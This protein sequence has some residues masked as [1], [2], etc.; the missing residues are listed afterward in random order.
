MAL[1]RMI[2][3]VGLTKEYGSRVAVSDLHFAVGKGEVVGFLG[4]NGAGKTTTLRMLSGFL[5]PTR[6]QVRVA[7][8][9]VVAEPLAARAK[10]GYMPE[11]SPSY[12]ELRVI[13]YLTFRAE[14]KGVPRGRRAAA[15]GRALELAN[16]TDRRGSVVAQLSKGYRQRL[17]LADALVADP[18]LLVLD[19]PTSGLDP[20]QIIEVRQVIRDLSEHH[21]VV[22]STHI[23]AEVDAVCDRA[24]VIARGKLVAEGTLD[25][26][27]T[28]GRASEGTL[29]VRVPANASVPSAIEDAVVARSELDAEYQEWRV[30]LP[31]ARR[32][33]ERWIAVLGQAGYQ[34]AEA[35]LGSASLEQ[36]FGALTREPEQDPKT[37]P[38]RNLESSE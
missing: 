5:G 6:G 20:N 2:E 4:P 17:G 35:R 27:R 22:L 33:M 3:A 16:L 36:V 11:T 14:L 8:F 31:E 23:L 30:R 15:V 37:E 26:L 34:V 7:G 1:P 10:L 19:E 18:P 28:R 38:E 32:S 12:P 9:D 21:T 25:A 13:E 24:I 29:V